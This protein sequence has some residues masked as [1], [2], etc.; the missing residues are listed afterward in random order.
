MKIFTRR[1]NCIFDN[2]RLKKVYTFKKF[3]IFIGTTDQKISKDKFVDMDITCS[4][5]NLIQ[6]CANRGANTQNI[7]YENYELLADV[8]N[9]DDK[10]NKLKNIIKN[11]IKYEPEK[12]EIKKKY[13][14]FN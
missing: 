5:K 6:F 12:E 11:L 9:N 13:T 14:I 1:L 2:S 4:K 8:E 10:I 7:N 3:P